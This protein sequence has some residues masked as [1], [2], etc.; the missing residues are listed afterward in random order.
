M[1][2]KPRLPVCL[3]RIADGAEAR[4]YARPCPPRILI[5]KLENGDWTFASPYAPEDEARWNALL[6]DAFGTRS[7]GVMNH[8]LEIFTTLCRDGEWDQERHYWHPRQTDFDALLAIVAAVAPENEAQAAYAA[9]LAALHISAMKLGEAAIKHYSDP[10]TVAL[11][12]KT[13]RAY[14]DGMEQLARL[15]GKIKPRTVNQTIQV[16]YCDNRSVDVSGGAVQFGGQPHA[17]S[18]AATI[19]ARSAV[20]SP[21]PD[22]GAAL[23]AA[24]RE[25]KERVQ[26]AWWGARLWRALWRAQR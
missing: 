20:P 12:S 5:E 25:G 13:V 23:S 11:L 24:S 7:C 8:F 21:C 17:A 9:Q 26:N 1:A 2:E 19:E 15:Q 14:G 10:R 3:D 6:F 18:N 4:L 16:V 22:D